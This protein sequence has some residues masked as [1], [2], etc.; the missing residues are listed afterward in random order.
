M[1]SQTLLLYFI[2]ITLFSCKEKQSYEQLLSKAK[3]AEI[4]GD[5]ETAKSY[6]KQAIEL[7]PNTARAY[8][9]MAG[10]IA[11]ESPKSDSVIKLLNIAYEIDSTDKITVF[12]LAYINGRIYNNYSTSID[13]YSNLIE[14]TND[15][16]SIAMILA[17]RANMFLRLGDTL[18]YCN[19][20]K[21]TL[22]YLDH[23]QLRN[24]YLINCSRY[25]E[26]NGNINVV[27]DSLNKVDTIIIEK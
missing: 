6:Y 10:V 19:D 23:E 25:M 3:Q 8:S 11:N 13:Y 5:F 18:N 22:E 14:L 2:F 15:S 17:N 26:T 21:R 12:N 27:L 4:S 24:N 1:R 7:N 9:L 20:L 16:D